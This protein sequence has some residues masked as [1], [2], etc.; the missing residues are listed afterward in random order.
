M[1]EK[2]DKAKFEKWIESVAETQIVS[3]F[4]SF[5]EGLKAGR[6]E[7][8]KKVKEFKTEIK[9]IQGC[10]P[11]PN[12]DYSEGFHDG[13]FAIDLISDR[14]FGEPAKPKQGRGK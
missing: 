2:E 14:I 5:L 6:E 3:N 4:E 9:S 12:L 1:T 13:V 7:W 8:E 11:S 10:K